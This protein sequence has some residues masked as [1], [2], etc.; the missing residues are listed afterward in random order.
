[1]P[2]D[3]R[4]RHDEERMASALALAE[5]VRRRTAPNPWVGCVIE[6]E[7]A[8]VAEGATEAP[9]G[10]HAE[11]VALRSAGAAARGATVYVTLEPCAHHGRTPPCADA[12]IE[13]GVARVVVGLEDPDRNVAGAG[14]ARLR[15]AGID[16]IVGPGADAVR[17][18]LAPYLHH[19]R[20]A[21][22]WCVVKTAVSVDGRTAAA[23][24][25][26]RWITGPEARADAHELRADSQAIVVGAGTALA[27]RPALTVRDADPAPARPPLRVLL[28]AR[29]RV[30]AYGP[31][32]DPALAPTLV[33][34]TDA[35]PPPVVD[36]WRAAGAKVEIVRGGPNGVDLMAALETLGAHGVLQAM[37]E[38]GATLHGALVA[39]DLLDHLV[40]YVGGALLGSAGTPAFRWPGPPSL[41]AAPRLRLEGARILGGD[42]RLDYGVRSEDRA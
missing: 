7:G 23:D 4:E 38:G 36:D 32:F 10:A 1:V 22:A 37:V 18:Q 12:L 9:G 19:R 11:I 40:V 39:A 35:A 16:V 20:T 33:L 13:A 26:S 30:P 14:V 34:T 15:A 2:T 42:V 8:I 21:R 6:R 27:D 31:L 24:G 25:S 3:G 41:D 5:G 28:D 17:H 29:G